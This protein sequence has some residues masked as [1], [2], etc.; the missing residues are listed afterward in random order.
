MKFEFVEQCSA[1]DFEIKG[2]FDGSTHLIVCPEC[3]RENPI[4][5]LCKCFDCEKCYKGSNFDCDI[6]LT[7]RMD[8]GMSYYFGKDSL[9][10][11][12]VFSSELKESANFEY[13][14][15]G[16]CYNYFDRI[17][18]K[19]FEIGIDQFMKGIYLYIKH[20]GEFDPLLWNRKSAFEIFQ[21][22]IH[23]CLPY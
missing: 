9:L 16:A 18:L 23:G 10:L 3:S 14:L 19:Y 7:V 17:K 11:K 12:S 4:C 2:V 8:D 20:V 6:V 1:C 5:N 22:A 21:F 15:D 13:F